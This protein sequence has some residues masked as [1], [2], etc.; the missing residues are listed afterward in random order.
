[1]AEA[2]PNAAPVEAAER[3]PGLKP[4]AALKL[5]E[6]ADRLKSLHASGTPVADQ[7]ALTVT[8]PE[9]L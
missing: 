2:D 3:P 8:A 4:A 7:A 6:M 1:V 9:G 5:L